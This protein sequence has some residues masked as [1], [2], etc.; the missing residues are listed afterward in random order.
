[1]ILS[2]ASIY[3]MRTRLGR[4]PRGLVAKYFPEL[5]AFDGRRVGTTN[6]GMYRRFRE[7]VGNRTSGDRRML[8]A[9]GAGIAADGHPARSAKPPSCANPSMIPDRIRHTRCAWISA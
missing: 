1:M 4:L 5:R 6:G 8:A 7:N 9:Y 2:I 3:S